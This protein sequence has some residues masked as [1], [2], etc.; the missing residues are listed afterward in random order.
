MTVNENV[1]LVKRVMSV[2]PSICNDKPKTYKHLN[3]LCDKPKRATFSTQD[4]FK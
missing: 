1:A 4:V 2:K 3:N